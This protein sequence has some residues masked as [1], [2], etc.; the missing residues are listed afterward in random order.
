MKRLI[1]NIA[2]DNKMIQVHRKRQDNELSSKTFHLTALLILFVILVQDLYSTTFLNYVTAYTQ[3]GFAMTVT[4]FALMLLT[5]LCPTLCSELKRFV[6]VF[7]EAT[8]CAQAVVLAVFWTIVFVLLVSSFTVSSHGEGVDLD[9]FTILLYLQI[10]TVPAG[11]VYLEVRRSKL[12][13]SSWHRVMTNIPLFSYGLFAF[14]CSYLGNVYRYPVFNFKDWR[15]VPC[16]MAVIAV[17][18]FA[19]RYGRSLRYKDK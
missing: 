13:F 7:T 1:A 10:H 5:D 16:V 8:W 12:E 11:L 9:L 4:N 3:W 15:S 19:F 14:L 18:E 6:Q 2:L 17:N